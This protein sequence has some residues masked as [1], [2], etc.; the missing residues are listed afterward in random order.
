MGVFDRRI[1]SYEYAALVSDALAAAALLHDVGHTPFSHILEEPLRGVLAEY[2]AIPRDRRPH[3]VCGLEIATRV[4]RDVSRDR[5]A[6]PPYWEEFRT[7]TLGILDPSSPNG[8][9]ASALHGLLSSQV[10]IDRMD[11]LRRDTSV[12]GSEYGRIN[13]ARIIDSLELYVG[14][15]EEVT[16]LPGARARPAIERLWSEREQAYRWIYMHPR[17]VAQDFCLADAVRLLLRLRGETTTLPPD[18]QR[19]GIRTYGDFFT[20]IAPQINYVTDTPLNE[21]EDDSLSPEGLSLFDDAAVI[22]WAKTAYRLLERIP[23]QSLPDGAV[24]LMTRLRGFLFRSKP[25]R[26][27]WKNFEGYE[28]MARRV[29]SSS[30]FADGVRSATAHA[31]AEAAFYLDTCQH[32]P[33]RIFTDLLQKACQTGQALGLADRLDRSTTGRHWAVVSYP[34][35]VLDLDAYFLMDEETRPF[36]AASPLTRALAESTSIVSTVFILVD[37]ETA[38]N[39]EQVRTELVN[40]LSAYLPSLLV[41]P[42]STD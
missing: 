40:E 29:I 24:R 32:H 38:P 8:S 25:F 26:P 5:A 11:Y 35:D 13:V 1:P 20:F 28:D 41:G 6:L 16:I 22:S 37:S 31:P 14:Q 21:V 17:V 15:G 36:S 34:F 19:P 7:L 39:L 4:L 23:P 9:W 27:V 2:L 3:E 30:A 10:D 42:L 12:T 33:T 18:E